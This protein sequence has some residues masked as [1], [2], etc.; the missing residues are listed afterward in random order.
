MRVLVVSNLYPPGG[1]GGYELRCFQVVEELRARGHEVLVMTSVL[2][3]AIACDLEHVERRLTLRGYSVVEPRGASAHRSLEFDSSVSQYANTHAVLE[4]IERFGP[5]VVYLFD[6][7]GLGGLAIIDALTVSGIPWTWH[8]M[9]RV[10]VQLVLGASVPIAALYGIETGKVFDAGSLISI[11]RNLVEEIEAQPRIGTLPR[12]TIVPGWAKPSEFVLEREY[13]RG[14]ILRFVFAGTY[15]THKGIDLIVQA[16]GRLRD[17]GQNFTIDFFGFGNY[18]QFEKAALA[19]G[20]VSRLTFNGVIGQSEL[21]AVFRNADVFLFPSLEREPF[22]FVPLEAASEGCV[23][24]ITGEAGVSERLVNGVHCVKISRDVD[25]LTEAMLAVADEKFDLRAFGQRAR[26]VVDYSLS[27]GSAVSQIETVLLRSS[28]SN[29]AR[30]DVRKVAALERFKE[31][32]A[33][34]LSNEEVV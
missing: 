7:V 2:A 34:H 3:E 29:P 32:V 6:L 10:P 27:L 1:L 9:D 31:L 17:A 13:R 16:A 5:D 26:F 4:V 21:R 28:R 22:G 18:S 12:V 23:P 30:R 8:L 15:G 33:L 25:S 19:L 20:L 24:I 11:S 14:G